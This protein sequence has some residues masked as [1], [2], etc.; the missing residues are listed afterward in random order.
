MAKNKTCYLTSVADIQALLKDIRFVRLRKY[1]ELECQLPG[2][3]KEENHRIYR[4]LGRLY[5]ACG[6]GHGK[7][8]GIFAVIAAFLYGWLTDASWSNYPYEMATLV[9]VG[10]SLAAKIAAQVSAKIQLMRFLRDLRA[11]YQESPVQD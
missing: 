7:V 3:S 8:V 10:L 2:L 1:K 6:C 4:H 5:F 11:L 9:V